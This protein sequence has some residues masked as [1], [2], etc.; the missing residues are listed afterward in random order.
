[1]REEQ[2]TKRQNDHVSTS[3]S[4]WR[5]ASLFLDYKLSKGRDHT[6]RVTEAPSQ[7]WQH[8]LWRDAEGQDCIPRSWDSQKGRKGPW[9]RGKII[10]TT[11]RQRSHERKGL[12]GEPCE[13]AVRSQVKADWV[14]RTSTC[15]TIWFSQLMKDHVKTCYC[16]SSLKQASPASVDSEIR[17]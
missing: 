11:W 7:V 12:Q 10:N 14:L 13:R 15:L 4:E 6:V 17:K 16:S 9:P 2:E 8:R 1:M 5:N 3:L